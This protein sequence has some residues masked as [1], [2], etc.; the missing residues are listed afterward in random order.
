MNGLG[1]EGAFG[2]AE[3]IK[4]SGTISNLDVTYN[5]ISLPGAQVIG[6]ALEGNE[7][8]KVF[9]VTWVCFSL[10]QLIFCFEPLSYFFVQNGNVCFVLIP[11]IPN[12]QIVLKSDM[13]HSLRSAG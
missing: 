10:Y 12:S 9:K 8:L 1:N 13:C 2:V 3:I 5:R 7:V 6:K 11:L 4:Q